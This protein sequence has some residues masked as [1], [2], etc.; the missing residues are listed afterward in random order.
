MESMQAQSDEWVLKMERAN[1]L[2]HGLGLLFGLISIP[3]LIARAAQN[4]DI[5]AT[6][7]AAAFGFGFLAVYTCSTLYHSFHRPDLK[8]I[9]RILDHVSIYFLIT[10][11]YTPF[12]LM[13]LYNATGVVLLS[14]L[15]TLALVGAFFKLFFTG[16]YERLSLV[17]YLTMGWMIIFVAKPV[18]TTLPMDCLA[19]IA[20]GGA[21][22][23]VGVIFY[24][25]ESLPY[26]HAIWHL[27]VLGGSICHYVAVWRVVAG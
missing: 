1:S 22:Y 2:T 14:I 7:G 21:F 27:F 25:W 9:L 13:Y 11:S 16:H 20:A 4:Q 15:W 17:I 5:E 3:M 18:F 12:V 6:I 23:T 8:R 10:G 24:R 19:W 26:H